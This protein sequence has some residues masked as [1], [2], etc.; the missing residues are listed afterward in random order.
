MTSNT[1]PSIYIPTDKNLFDVLQQKKI[2]HA[3]LVKF[4]RHRGIIVST[5]LHK[6]ELSKVISRLQFDYHDYSYLVALLENPNRKEKTT[7]TTIKTDAGKED[8][9]KAC[10]DVKSDN[11]DDGDTYQVKKRGDTSVLVVT[12]TEVDFT[13]TELKQRS[14]KTCEIELSADEDGTSVRRPATKKGRDIA[15]KLKQALTVIKG[16]PLEEES[17]SLES[18]TMPEARSYFF[19]ELIKGVS[20]FKIDNVS[21]V[22]VY[23][24]IDTLD[25]DNEDED[26]DNASASFAGFIRKANLSGGGVLESAEFGQLHKRGFFISKVIWTA[27]DETYGG[28]VVEFEAQ[29][30]TPASCTDFK[31][32][33]RGIRHFNEHTKT[34]N[35]TRK[36]ANQTEARRYSAI[37]EKT[38]KATFDKVMAKYGDM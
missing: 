8:L 38:A 33:I 9:L 36:P 11:D 17:I 20:G 37:L 7:R 30:G 25:D 15:N 4:L 5:N 34:H 16:Q 35:A 27:E 28:H 22:D 12:Y 19:D 31:Y 18:L 24:D 3:E 26:L 14:T 29:F 32:T 13:K 23:H 6:N 21:S 10:Q 2:K 1:G